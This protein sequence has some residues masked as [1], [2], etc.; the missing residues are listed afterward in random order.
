MGKHAGRLIARIAGR[1]ECAVPLP[2]RRLARHHRAQRG[3]RRFRL[4]QGQ[5]LARMVA[6]EHRRPLFF[7]RLP[8]PLYVSMQWLRSYLTYRRGAR[9]ITGGA[10]EV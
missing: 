10:G 7:G 1:T 4:D 6:M 3:D 5:G 8:Q 9:L 2:S